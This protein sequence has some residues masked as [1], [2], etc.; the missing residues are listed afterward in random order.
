MSNNNKKGFIE[1]IG[2][3]VVPIVVVIV[4]VILLYVLQAAVN[5]LNF[6][7]ENPWVGWL[8]VGFL[9]IVGVLYLLS[10]FGIIFTNRVRYVVRDDFLE[11][12]PTEV[13]ESYREAIANYNHGQERS[14]S[15]MM[16][17]TLEV[18]IAIRFK[19]AGLE[20]LIRGK[21]LPKRIELAKQEHFISS[22]IANRLNQLKWIGDLGAH[23]YKVKIVKEDL[24]KGLQTL[25]IA[26]EHM[27]HEE[28]FQTQK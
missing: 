15:V 7:S 3:S 4:A 22:S 18:A 24:E 20:N 25:R 21:N 5:V 16:R 1:E 12:F 10:K 23:D 6:L 19:K 11:K 9:F 17:R 8:I 14:C 26:L 28:D 27:F 2:E 13:G